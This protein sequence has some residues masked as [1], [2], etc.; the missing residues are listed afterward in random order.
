LFKTI[1]LAGFIVYQW[2]HQYTPRI[3]PFFREGG[4]TY[5]L[6][7]KR[8]GYNYKAGLTYDTGYGVRINVW[9]DSGDRQF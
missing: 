3:L 5:N 7:Y 2:T 9:Y 4:A 1:V 6:Q 8:G